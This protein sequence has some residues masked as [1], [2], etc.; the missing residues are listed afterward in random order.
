MTADHHSF[1]VW[2]P[3]PKEEKSKDM[4]WRMIEPLGYGDKSADGNKCQSIAPEAENHVAD[5][6]VLD[7]A[8]L[9]FRFCT[10]DKSW[11]EATRKGNLTAASLKA[12]GES[13]ISSETMR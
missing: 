12:C 9:G 8:A 6:I 5:I 3:R 2:G 4:V 11:L 1:A 7:D 13:R 10:N